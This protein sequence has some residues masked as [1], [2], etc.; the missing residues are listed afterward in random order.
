MNSANDCDLLE[1]LQDL[2]FTASLPEAV[3]A[4]LAETATWRELETGEFLFR[5]GEDDRHLYMV[6]IGGVALDMNVPGRGTTRILTLGAGDMV[7]WSAIVGSGRMTTS[8]VAL[9]PTSVIALDAETLRQIAD[10]DHEVG[11]HVMRRMATALA[12]RLVATRLQ[13]LDLFD[14]DKP[15]V[16]TDVGGTS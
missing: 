4:R 14:L 15:A 3:L 10:S 16:K 11:Y 12:K 2:S 13:L 1:R 8:G 7:G 9:E 6:C 5:E